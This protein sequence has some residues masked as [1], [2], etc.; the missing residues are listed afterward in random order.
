MCNHKKFMSLLNFIFQVY[1][2]NATGI[3]ENILSDT[4][5]K[6]ARHLKFVFAGIFFG[7]F[8]YAFYPCYDF[9][10]N[11]NLTL[12]SPMRLPF[13]DNTTL[14][15]YLIL[16]SVNIVAAFWAVF[17]TYAF[18]CLFLSY[19][20]VYDGM[21]SLIEDDFHSF[22]SMWKTENQLII[23]KRILTFR[24]IMLELMDLAR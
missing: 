7:L 2:K 22:D 4:T 16:S 3:R 14:D 21:V 1:E 11:G 10:F 5:K 19:V 20:D 6:I 9:L 24:N 17:G 18:S 8:V 23:N 15:G 12:V 13:V